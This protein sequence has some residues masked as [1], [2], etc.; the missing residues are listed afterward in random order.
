[1]ILVLVLGL[2]WF[3]SFI[4]FYEKYPQIFI[5]SLTGFVAP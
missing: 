4:S 1:M 2:V 3:C 5:I